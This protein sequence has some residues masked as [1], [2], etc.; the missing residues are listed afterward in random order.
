MYK[1]DSIK[2]DGFWHKFNASCDFNHDVNIIIGRNGTGKTTFMNILDAILT[3][4]FDGLMNNE[5]ESAVIKLSKN[6]KK[7]TIKAKKIDDI[8]MPFMRIEYQISRTKH[9]VRISYA[10]DSSARAASHYRRRFLEES[11]EVRDQLQQLVSLSSLSVYRL[12][13][14]NDYELRDRNGGQTIAPVDYKLKELLQGL[15][16]YQIELSQRARSISSRL[17]KRVLKS[18]LYTEGDSQPLSYELDFNKEEEKKNLITAYKQLNAFDPDA[19]RKINS[20]VDSIDKTVSSIINE[21]GN[22]GANVDFRSIEAFRKT[23]NI[24]KMSLESEDERTIV[25]SQIDLFINIINKFIENK[26]FE[27]ENGRLLIISNE[28]HLECNDLSSGEKQLL[29]IMIETLLQKEKPFIFLTDEPELSL[30]IEWQ[31]N[32]IPA[33][34]K[35]NPNAQ[36]IAATHSPEVASQYKNSIVNMGNIVNG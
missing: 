7:K 5:F 28:E 31:R 13:N 27:F 2:I 9:I 8:D 21:S 6:G 12:R 26:V 3:V 17:Q 22:K 29:I 11:E 34:T 25:F 10:A 4:N 1:I 19:R 35:L 23:R 20:H 24:I 36:I 32:I 14:E 18:I 16:H 33:I 30:H 15:M